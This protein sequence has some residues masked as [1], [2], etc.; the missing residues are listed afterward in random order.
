MF[1]LIKGICIVSLLVVFLVGCNTIGSTAQTNESLLNGLWTTYYDD[2]RDFYHSYRFEDGK[3]ESITFDGTINMIG[4]Y[5]IDGDNIDLSVTHVSG[6]E[7]DFAGQLLTR[8]EFAKTQAEALERIYSAPTMAGFLE[9]V[10]NDPVE[11][12][13]N[14]LIE[15]FSVDKKQL[16]LSYSTE[17]DII[18]T[19]QTYEQLEENRISSN[20]SITPEW[21]STT[22]QRM[23]KLK[24]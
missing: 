6:L 11:L 3:F 15:K 17:K 4:T 19:G 8:E 20:E 14:G 10:N 5:T 2:G 9:L 13:F 7:G 18:A 23:K 16:V 24:H 22:Y 21:T 1:K 12:F